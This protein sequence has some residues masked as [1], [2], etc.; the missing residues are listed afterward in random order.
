VSR[1]SFEPLSCSQGEDDFSD[2]GHKGDN[3]L[4]RSVEHNPG[5]GI[6]C[7]LNRFSPD[8]KRSNNQTTTQ[9]YGKQTLIPGKF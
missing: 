4:R 7:E 1:H 6:V 5:P 3:L 9:Q 2:R 8:C